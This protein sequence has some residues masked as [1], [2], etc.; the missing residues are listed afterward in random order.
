MR[1][2]TFANNRTSGRL[3]RLR[4]ARSP[5]TPCARLLAPWP[6]DT[7]VVLDSANVQHNLRPD[8]IHAPEKKQ[9]FERGVRASSLAPCLAS[10]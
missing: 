7:L 9:P 1:H 10:M 8:G 6:S 3:K 5:T 2:A 4:C